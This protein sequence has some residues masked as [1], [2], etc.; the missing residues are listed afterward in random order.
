[1]QLPLLV[2]LIVIGFYFLHLQMA[3]VTYIIVFVIIADLLTGFVSNI[4]GGVGAVIRGGKSA[5]KTEGEEMS[6]A[7]PKSPEAKKFFGEGLSR[8]G[9]KIGEGEKAKMEGK[10]IMNKR[11]LFDIAGQASEDF[12]DGIMKLFRK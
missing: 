10:K 7:N 11:G 4:F 8:I 1:M 5:I 2:L 9:E 6:K 12:L 3:F